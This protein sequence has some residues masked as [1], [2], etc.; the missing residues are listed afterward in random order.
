VGVCTGL[1][2]RLLVGNI[3]ASAALFDPFSPSDG[4][5]FRSWE[6]HDLLVAA[7][8]LIRWFLAW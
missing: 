4:A 8:L 5:F 3:A 6:R 7:N 2:E 1:I